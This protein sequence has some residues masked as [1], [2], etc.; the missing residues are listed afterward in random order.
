MTLKQEDLD[1]A[2]QSGQYV[3]FDLG[4]MQRRK[5]MLK[6]YYSGL[7]N[8]AAIKQIAQEFNCRE[9]ALYKDWSRREKWEPFIWEQVANIEDAKKLVKLLQLARETAAV[10]M[11]DPRKGGNARVGAIG[12]YT[13]AIVR[14]VELLQSLGQL[15]KQAQPSV[16]IN[17]NLTQVNATKNEALLIDLTKM[18]E[19][20]KRAL[21]R[22][23]EALTRAETAPSP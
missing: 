8:L 20:D 22:A 3:H 5:V 7:L 1:K 17:E 2:V 12:R 4:L 15:P 10:I 14:E 18:S 11:N 21:L 19:D 23:E 13:E 6:T 16:V 9:I